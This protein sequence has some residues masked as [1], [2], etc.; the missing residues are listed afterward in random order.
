MVP[1]EAE[2]SIGFAELNDDHLLSGFARGMGEMD[3]SA[4]ASLAA[5]SAGQ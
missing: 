5:G 2:V 4:L 1:P 3:W